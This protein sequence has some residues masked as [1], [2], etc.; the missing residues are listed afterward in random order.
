MERGR[1]G[2]TSISRRK[3]GSAVHADTLTKKL[4]GPGMA[5]SCAGLR[6]SLEAL[7]GGTSGPTL[8]PLM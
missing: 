4:S 1:G 7:T 5:N 6:P 8:W 2:L 3:P